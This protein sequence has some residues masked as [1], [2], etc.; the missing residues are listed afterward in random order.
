MERKIVVD[1]LAISYKGLFSV[2]ELYRMVDFWF[3]EK[4]YTKH[5]LRIDEEV[6]EDGKKMFVSKD[7]Y[8]KISDY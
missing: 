2:K 3:M 6:T 5:E 1:H 8:R 7:P 4:G